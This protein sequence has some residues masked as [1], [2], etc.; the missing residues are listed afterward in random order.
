MMVC[1]SVATVWTK[2]TSPRY[3]D[4]LALNNPVDMEGWIK[5]TT[6]EEQLALC[7]NNLVQTQLLYG[8][9]VFILEEKEQ[10]AHVL[11]PTQ[12]SRKDER[13][14]PGWVPMRQLSTPTSIFANSKMA[15][16]ISP[17][18]TISSTVQGLKK[19]SD[20]NGL[21]ISFLTR[22]PV[23]KHT[24]DFVEVATPHG[25]GFLKASDVRIVDQEEEL[26]KKRDKPILDVA[27]TF[28]GLPYLWG[29]M[30]AFGFDCSGFVYSVYRYFGITLPRDASDQANRG[31]V[32]ERENLQVGDLLFFAYEKGKGA[33]HHVG[34]Y[35]GDDH[36]IHSPKTGK[37]IEIIPLSGSSYEEELIGGRRYANELNSV[38][39]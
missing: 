25:N 10:W 4:Q 28:V 7:K 29:G 8:T 31:E 24:T 35:A 37:S 13:G 21:V 39:C 11:I 6:Y 36:M 17:I 5:S 9:E 33:V 26:V 32:I 38:S 2:P 15:Q 3:I 34:M 16:V 23:V 14:Y 1:V 22:L 27:K 20:D 12:P 30:S 18:V 19:K